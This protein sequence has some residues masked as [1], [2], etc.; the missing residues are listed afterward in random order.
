LPLSLFAAKY[1]YFTSGFLYILKKRQQFS[2]TQFTL[3]YLRFVV[4]IVVFPVPSFQEP[5]ILVSYHHIICWKIST[6]LRL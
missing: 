4:E 2:W 1:S 3:E 6:Q 5:R